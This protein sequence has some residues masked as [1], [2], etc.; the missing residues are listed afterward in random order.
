MN[1]YPYA[2]RQWRRLRAAVLAMHPV[3]EYCRQERATVADHRTRIKDG[4]AV[5]DMANIVASC[6]ACHQ[7]KRQAERSGREFTGRRIK[8]GVDP[9][10]GLP[11][12]GGHWWKE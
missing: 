3:C 8:A 11:I 10:T 4:G 6:W 12:G 7:S 1:K 9:A 5:W 2:T